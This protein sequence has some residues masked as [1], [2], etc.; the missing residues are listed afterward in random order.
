MKR[1]I[2]LFSLIF[3]LTACSTNL[4]DENHSTNQGEEKLTKLES[5]NEKLQQEIDSLQIDL[6]Y[7]KEEA[8]YY[9]HWID[10]FLKDYSEAQL[11]E[12][13]KK[14][15]KYELSIND[16]PVPK[17]GIVETKKSTIEISLSEKQADFPILPD[18][19]FIKGEISGDYMDHLKLNEKPTETY[20]TDGTIVT[21]IHHKYKNLKK[22]S[23]ITFTITDELKERLGLETTQITIIKK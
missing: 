23:K 17:N 9:K 19:I 4:G 12:L 13:A 22:G 14:E 11:K 7:K 18:E 20:G 1:I 3:I 6:N 21:A 10:E 8:E 15:W 2:L 5:K 16:K